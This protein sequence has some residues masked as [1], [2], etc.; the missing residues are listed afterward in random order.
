MALWVFKVE[1]KAPIEIKAKTV[2]GFKTNTSLQLSSVTP[3]SISLHSLICVRLSARCCCLCVSLSA[4]FLP[5]IIRWQET[6]SCFCLKERM[7]WRSSPGE[8]CLITALHPEDVPKS[9]ISSEFVFCLLHTVSHKLLHYVYA[10]I[11]V[12]RGPSESHIYSRL[13]FYRGVAHT[14]RWFVCN[15]G[16]QQRCSDRTIW[17]THKIKKY[18][19]THWGVPQR[20]W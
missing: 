13:M 18:F 6:R 1:Q 2:F 9:K 17:G 16:N 19:L 15:L 4:V 5:V 8:T 11:G 20:F 7:T 14:A 3:F 10:P 12:Q